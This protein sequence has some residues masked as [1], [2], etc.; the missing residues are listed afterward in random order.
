MDQ[1][2]L[3]TMA[4]GLVS[5]W[6]VQD[7]QFT[8]EKKQL[9]LHIDFTV[10]SQLS[11]P[12]C[13]VSCPVHDTT[14]KKW[15]HLDFFNHKTY[16]H[17]R[18]PRVQCPEHGVR[19]VTIPWARTGS[20]FTL[21]FESFVMT[22]AADMPVKCIADLVGVTDKRLWRIVEH[23]VEEAVERIDCFD[24]E[25][26]GVDETSRKK[27][28]NY[29]TVFYDMIARRILFITDGKDAET[30]DDFEHF[31]W[32]HNG[33]G[34]NIFEVSSDMSPA[35]IKGARECLERAKI[36]CD[37]FHVVKLLSQAMNNTRKD[38]VKKGAL[39]KGSMYLWLTNPRKLS[40]EQRQRLSVLQ[41]AYQPLADAYRLK[42]SFNELYKQENF[43]DA[44][45]F[46]RAWIADAYTSGN[47]HFIKAA[48][49]IEK[50]QDGILRWQISR[51]TNAVMEGLNSLIQA[52]K[53][54]ARGY[55]TIKYIRWM[56]YLI[57]GKL[58]LRLPT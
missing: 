21:L 10:G 57:G 37:R 15:R 42:E 48:A 35:F 33:N 17:A 22:L 47:K 25:V 53:R 52:A 44:E 45:G 7:I 5:P 40:D 41:D 13:E 12:C 26:V 56:A 11:C 49:T 28:H 38:E 14:Q 6:E 54:R 32:E 30:F 3:F 31:L 18:I 8:L 20:G 50:H 29:I 24:T 27:H 2:T 23:Y 51:I 43:A 55:R 9:D 16:L 36:T 19:Q 4:L 39:I 1:N 34:S 46:L 58:D